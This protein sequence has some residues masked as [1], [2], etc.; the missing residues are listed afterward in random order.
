MGTAFENIA[1]NG[2]LIIEGCDC[3]G[4][5]VQMLEADGYKVEIYNSV[6][7][8]SQVIIRI[9]KKSPDELAEEELLHD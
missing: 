1:L 6:P 4:K 5:F 8:N 3:T 2:T 7:S 9:R